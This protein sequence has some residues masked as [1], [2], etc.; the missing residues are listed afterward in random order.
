MIS[1][2]VC[3]INKRLAEQ[4]KQ[5][6]NDT[7]G[8]PWELVLIDN[9]ELQASIAHVYNTGAQRAQYDLL[10]FVHEDVLFKTKSWGATIVKLFQTVPNLGALGLAGAK[11]KSRALSGWYT[12]IPDFDCCNILHINGQKEE[13]LIYANPEAGSTIQEVVCLDG[14]FICATRQLWQQVNFN[15][16]LLNGFHC[17]DIDFSFRATKISTVAVTYEIDVIHLTEGG[18]FGNEWVDNTI[19]WHDTSRELLPFSVGG[20]AHSMQK[21]DETTITSYWLKRLKGEPITYSRRVEWI[22][23]TGALRH[24]RLWPEIAMFL[25]FRFYKRLTG[26]RTKLNAE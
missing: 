24:I 6:I 21:K 22:V 1:V 3:S 13:Q 19:L 8:V 11:Y 5:N 26:T 10:C 23:K 20:M 12:G 2:I 14:V 16:R 17:Y 9:D 25:C 7:I 18:S 15:Q 4:L